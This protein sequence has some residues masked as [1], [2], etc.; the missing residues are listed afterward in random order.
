MQIE[1]HERLGSPDRRTATRAV[2]Y[3]DHK[4]P[5]AVFIQV[6]PVNIFM[7][8][9]GQPGFEAALLNLG[10]RDTSVVTVVDPKA[11]PDLKVT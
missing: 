2:V 10:V 7:S 1:S 11:L 3:D 8:F 6:S 9:K 4:N 5:I